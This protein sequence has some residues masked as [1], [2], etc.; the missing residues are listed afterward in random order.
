[1]RL[2]RRF[3]ERAIELVRSGEI[4]SGIH[5][6]IG[7]EAVA[8]GVGAALRRDDV[9]MAHHRAHGHVLAKGTDPGRLLA[10]MA[11]R[12]GGVARGRGGS[13][14][15]SDFSVG[16][17]GCTGTVGHGAAI[18]AG[19]AWALARREPTGSRS[20]SSATGRSTRAR[21]SSHSTW[22]RCGGPG[23]LRLREQPVRDHRAGRP[24]RRRLDH[25]PGRGVRHPGRSCDGM[26][27]DIVYEAT[28]AAVGR[29][30]AGEPT[31]L[32]CLTYRF[33]G[34]HTFELTAGRATGIRRRSPRGAPATRWRCRPAGYRKACG[35]GSTTRSKRSW[36]PRSVRDGKPEARSGRGDG[37]PLLGRGQ[38]P[39][40]KRRRAAQGHRWPAPLAAPSEQEG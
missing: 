4:V 21:C 10:E 37:L 7:Q 14:H 30:R 39:R 3:E 23:R 38:A 33:D 11:G 28:A 19:A 29:A 20:P 35:A 12:A 1:M 2:I 32:E 13:F 6:C 22:R 5:P 31:F 18:A 34:H 9:M 15:P 25:R 26:D 36:R 17:L 16:V 40:R 24:D 8:A 27:P